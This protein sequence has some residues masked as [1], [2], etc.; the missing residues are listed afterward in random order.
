MNFL[1]TFRKLLFVLLL[2]AVMPISVLAFSYYSTEN[3]DFDTTLTEGI[4]T[5]YVNPSKIYITQVTTSSSSLLRDPA[6]WVQSL[7]YY[8]ITRLH[9][10]D[11]HI[12]TC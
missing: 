12:L 1:K 5:I 9:F 2:I 7:Y 11:L 3:Q 10:P 8:S 4:G 6:K